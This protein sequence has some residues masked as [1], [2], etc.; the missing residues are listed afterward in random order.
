MRVFK[1][2]MTVALCCCTMI[3]RAQQN[4]NP[5]VPAKPEGAVEG[6][7][8]TQSPI[9]APRAGVHINGPAGASIDV[10]APP[11]DSRVAPS[12]P[13]GWRYKF[14]RGQWWYWLPGNTWATWD[15]TRWNHYTNDDPARYR[16]GY[17]GLDDTNAANPAYRE[18]TNT[19]PMYR[20]R[21]YDDGYYYRDRPL[22]RYRRS[23]W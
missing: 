17:R 19:R 2:L 9:P 6:L 22:R 18:G 3:A 8:P 7:P 12:G 10:Q 4:E 16:T 1:L 11:A 20:S 13:N 21:Y 14:H 15:G 5:G 23:V